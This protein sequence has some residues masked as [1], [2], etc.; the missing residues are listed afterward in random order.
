M[1]RLYE[2]I[3][4]APGGRVSYADYM[5][6]ALY[7]ERFG[8]YMRERAKIGKEGEFFYEQLIRA[9]VWQSA[10]FAL[11]SDGGTERP[12][13]RCLRVGGGDGRLALSV[14]EE[15]KKKVHIHTTACRIRSS[16]KARSTAGASA[17]RFNPQPRRWSNMTMSLAG[18]PSVGRFP[19]LCLATN[20]L[21]RFPFTSL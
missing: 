2:Q 4:A 11:G 17:K 3:A 16:T 8:Y 19:A 18:W 7:D 21:M 20:F 12:A 5:Q 10:C 9:G 15:W 14:L 1:G 6:M 13:A